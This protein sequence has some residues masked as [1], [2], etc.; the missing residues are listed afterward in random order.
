MADDRQTR[1]SSAAV[2]VIGV[3]ILTLLLLFALQQAFNR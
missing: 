1:V 3:E 2:R